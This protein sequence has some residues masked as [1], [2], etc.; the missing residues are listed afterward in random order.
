[1]GNRKILFL[2]EVAIFAALALLL[3]VI[4][5]LSFKVWAQ[6][7]S[8]S[9]SMIPVFL[10]AFRWGL[11]GGITTGVL[12]GFYQI[13]TG[14]Y[15][16]TIFQTLLDYVVAFGVLGFAGIVAYPMR[17]AIE[18]KH[19]KRMITLIFLGGLIGSF[20][21]FAGH[22]FAGLWFYGSLAPEGQPVW[23][24]SLVYNGGYMLPSFLLSTVILALLLYKRPKLI[25]L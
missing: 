11:K 5:F 4:P 12:F 24:Y 19:V 7:G 6:G 3:D 2:V 21:R 25:T 13:L 8:V 20:L 14:A 15:I 16:V 22:F 23:L 9:F 18:S 10:M 17:K 1:M